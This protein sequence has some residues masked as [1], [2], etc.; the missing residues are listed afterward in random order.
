MTTNNPVAT[1]L[2][3]GHPDKTGHV[4]RA[5]QRALEKTGASHANSVLLFLTSDYAHDPEPAIRAAARAA[6]CT[7]VT[8]ATGTGL[9]TDQEWVIDSSGAAAMV[10]TGRVRL[11]LSQQAD[12]NQL[13]LCLCTPQALSTN[14]LDEPI[15]RFGAITSDEFGHGPF[16]VWTSGAVVKDEFTEVTV[17]GAS[18]EI[19]VA[20]GVQ[21]LT[22]PLQVDEVKGF[23]LLRIANHPALH[24]LINA[25]PEAVQKQKPLP[26]H[27]VMCGV[28]FGEADTAIA[29]GRF[30]LDH[31]VAAD[32]HLRS[33]TLSHPLRPGERLFWA[34]RDRVSAERTMQK[35]AQDCRKTLDG[36]PDFTIMFPCLSRGPLFFGGTDKDLTVVRDSFPDTPIIGFYGNGEIAPLG[37]SSHIHQ[38]STV[39]AAFRCHDA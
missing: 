19:A 18:A 38:Y 32:P 27:M 23:D 39:L 34:M 17:N 26:L 15:K 3:H 22:A 20:R 11:G 33:V 9:L 8:G 25:L 6:S 37:E 14:W 21:V 7:Q 16:V 36:V 2:S 12:P 4:E 5:V 28:T 30:R 13:R 24:V 31:I 29:E 35:A 10:F 1:G